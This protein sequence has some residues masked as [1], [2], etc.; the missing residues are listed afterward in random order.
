MPG[1]TETRKRLG[2]AGIPFLAGLAVAALAIAQTACLGAPYAYIPGDSTPRDLSDKDGDGNG[3][4][5][6]ADPA[7]VLFVDLL[8]TGPAGSGREAGLSS[9]IV[10]SVAVGTRVVV[11]RVVVNQATDTGVDPEDR[12]IYCRMLGTRVVVDPATDTDVD[13]ED[14]R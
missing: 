10:C 5:P 14:R 12:R 4:G 2:L 11:D 13:P 3:G 7:I 9:G 8:G 6:G 1:N